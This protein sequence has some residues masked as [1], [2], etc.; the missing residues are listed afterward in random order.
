MR[1][2][3]EEFPFFP[4]DINPISLYNPKAKRFVFYDVK[5]KIHRQR[6]WKPVVIPEYIPLNRSFA[7]ISPEGG[8]STDWAAFYRELDPGKRKELL[9][10]CSG[11]APEDGTERF[12]KQL[13][14]ARHT[15]PKRPE[16]E[17]DL[18]LFMCVNFIQLYKSARLFRK[19]AR[20]DVLASFSQLQCDQAAAFGDAGQEAL[21]LEFRNAAARYFKTCESPG[22][23]RRFF[24]LAASGEE[25]RRERM[26]RDERR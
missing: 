2:E 18:M 21:Y 7:T 13:F 5:K 22:Y 15:D 24:G 1:D 12:R 17:V 16:H 19:G 11:D 23:N 8:R 14:Q 10:A 20:R 9:A 3:L 26:C 4:L 6:T 25:N